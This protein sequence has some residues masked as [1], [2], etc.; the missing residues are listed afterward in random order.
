MYENYK[1][2]CAKIRNDN[3]VIG[4]LVDI[5]LKVNHI[6]FESLGRREGVI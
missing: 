3:V 5:V 2:T 4:F 1:K 6:T